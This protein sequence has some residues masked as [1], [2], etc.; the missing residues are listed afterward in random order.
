MDLILKNSRLSGHFLWC[1]HCT[2]IILGNVPFV[3][4]IVCFVNTLGLSLLPCGGSWGLLEVRR[5]LL[6]LITLHLCYCSVTAGLIST[7]IVET[8]KNDIRG[9]QLQGISFLYLP[10]FI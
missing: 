1:S 5:S 6:I 10:L 2:F 7:V 4:F 9:G 3:G 8:D